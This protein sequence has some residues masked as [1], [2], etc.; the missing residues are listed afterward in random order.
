MPGII[1]VTWNYY[2]VFR[3]RHYSTPAQAAALAEHCAHARYMCN[4]AIEQLGS[5]SRG[6]RMP[7]YAKQDR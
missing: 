6:Q 1:C 5:R 2:C 4:L 7:G 3:F